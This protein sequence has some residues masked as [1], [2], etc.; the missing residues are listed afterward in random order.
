MA[1]NKDF[2]DFYYNKEK[3]YSNLIN[4]I[5]VS[6]EQR[7]YTNVYFDGGY[8]YKPEQSRKWIVENTSLPKFRGL[9]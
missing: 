5:E 9:V 6:E 1:T 2:L 4:K 3:Y 8:G 7:N